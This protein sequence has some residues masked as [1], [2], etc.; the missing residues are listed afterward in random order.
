MGVRMVRLRHRAGPDKGA[1]RYR[2]R[3]LGRRP[4][5]S[6]ALRTGLVCE[7]TPSGV[8]RGMTIDPS[9]EERFHDVH[10]GSWTPVFRFAL[11]LSN[12]WDAAEDLAQEA[13]ARLWIHR[14]EID[15]NRPLLP[16]LLTTTRRLAFDRFRR[17]RRAL[18]RGRRDDARTLDGD[19]RI[20]WLDVQQAMANLAPLD[21]AALTMVAISG[22]T[23][24]EAG[25]VL[26]T[27]AGAIRARISRA[28][29]MLGDQTA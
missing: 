17:I 6:V 7:S 19:D 5:G 22:L 25:D 10:A 26:G 16:W 9:F 2:I 23:P 1:N 15:W 29:R 28:R 13:F 11:A 8:Y 18:E 12:D 20:R 14:N 24:D 27:T 4:T 3:G 21:R